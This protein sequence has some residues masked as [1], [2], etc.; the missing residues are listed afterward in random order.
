[1]RVP[2]SCTSVLCSSV[3]LPAP[4]GE[5]RAL[6]PSP[7]SPARAAGRR[8]ASASRAGGQRARGS[9]AAPMAAS[10]S[11]AAS[12]SSLLPRH[13]DAP[14][15]SLAARRRCS[16]T[17]RSPLADAARAPLRRTLAEL[18]AITGG[19]TWPGRELA[20]RMRRLLE[21]L[22]FGSQTSLLYATQTDKCISRLGR[23][24]WRQSDIHHNASDPTLNA[25]ARQ[26]P[27]NKIGRTYMSLFIPTA[28]VD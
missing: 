17:P 22:R 27:Q 20:M 28:Y 18:V 4:W 7:P 8:P 3:L 2:R 13:A 14:P 26:L 23:D 5:E 9:G 6:L 10:S 15:S 1:L 19:R 12:S 16:R 11:A 24:C 21:K 25:C